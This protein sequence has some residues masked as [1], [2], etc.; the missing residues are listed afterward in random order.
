MVGSAMCVTPTVQSRERAG[1]CPKPWQNHRKGP[2]RSRA[3]CHPGNPSP[4]ERGVEIPTKWAYES[5]DRR[6]D[7]V[8]GAPCP[9]EV[10]ADRLAAGVNAPTGPLARL[11]AKA[12][13]L[14]VGLFGPWWR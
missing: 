7:P 5:A 8:S 13:G 10:V 6:D 12:Q 1:E 11:L 2:G 14:T 9:V 3:Q 4:E